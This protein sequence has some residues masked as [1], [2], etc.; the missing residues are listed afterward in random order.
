[1]IGGVLSCV[2]HGAGR[3]CHPVLKAGVCDRDEVLAVSE[4]HN[5]RHTKDA[6]LA[7]LIPILPWKVWDIAQSIVRNFV[8]SLRAL[9]TN[10]IPDSLRRST[11]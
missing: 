1:M 8:F 4:N 7:I 11:D 6:A 2:I 10:E 3:P 9:C 5:P